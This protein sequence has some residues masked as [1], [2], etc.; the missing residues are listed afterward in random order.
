MSS[1]S[2]NEIGANLRNPAVL[3]EIDGS[4][5]VTGLL[6]QP[7]RALVIVHK[8]AAGTATE[9]VP[10][11]ITSERSAIEQFGRGSIG[12]LMFRSL[13][14]NNAETEAWAMAVAEPAGPDI[15]AGSLTVTGA[16]TANGTIF[17]YLGGQR[18]QVAVASGA[19]AAAVATAIAAEI[20]ANPDL[21]IAGAD[22]GGG[23]VTLTAKHDGAVGNGIDVRVNYRLDEQLPAGIA[24]VVVEPQGASATPDIASAIAGLPGDTQYHVVASPFTDAATLVALDA[25][26]QD[27]WDAQ[28]AIPGVLIAHRD[29]THGELTTFG[30]GLNSHLLSI[31]GA[32]NS[33]TPPWEWAAARAGQV[34]KAAN[35]DPARPF[36]T[37]PLVGVLPP[38]PEDRFSF[39]ENNLLLFDG[40]ATFNVD[41]G[42]LVRIGRSITT[43]QETPFGAP[44]TA[45]LDLNTPLTLAFIRTAYVDRFK[46][47]FP[48]HKLANDGTNFASGQAVITPN[49]AKA[50]IVALYRELERLGIVEDT[51]SFTE[52]L[53]VVRNPDPT[54]LDVSMQP[55]LVN[56]LRVVAIKIQFRL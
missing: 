8:L 33:P 9:N 30:D 6:G 7:Y 53:V 13:F 18:I 46:R 10:V 27:R 49:I 17:L 24:V 40:V 29:G 47:K 4:Q 11:Q 31:T 21:P 2:F 41:A 15:A 35:R 19:A 45:F 12:H 51:D 56:G 1:I 34:A 16:A 50:E 43:Y 25:E 38:A 14:A 26:L 39:T 36:Q 52:S 28:R 5:A 22:A 48:R 54:R 37:L 3:A 23:V 44:D 20:T 42:G 55:N 32:K